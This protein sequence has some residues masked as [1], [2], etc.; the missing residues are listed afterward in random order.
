MGN[1]GD[2]AFLFFVVGQELVSPALSE[3]KWMIL[4]GVPGGTA[5]L[6]QVCAERDGWEGVCERVVKVDEKDLQNTGLK[7]ENWRI[8][9]AILQDCQ[10]LSCSIYWF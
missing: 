6:G 10:F 7:S 1:A 9:S 4:V 3:G 8:E 2:P 5:V